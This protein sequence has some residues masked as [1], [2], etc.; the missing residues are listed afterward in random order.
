MPPMPG[1]PGLPRS[2]MSYYGQ[3]DGFINGTFGRMVRQ[4]LDDIEIELTGACTDM[5]QEYLCFFYWPLCNLT[6]GQVLPVCSDS[7][8]SL[9]NNEECSSVLT[10]ATEILEERVRDSIDMPS[11]SC[12]TTTRELVGPYTESADCVTI[13]GEH[14][15]K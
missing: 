11:E 2:C 4:T 3:D 7:C 8:D 6:N 15:R 10:I 12:D 14:V 5:V 1:R 9:F 13:E